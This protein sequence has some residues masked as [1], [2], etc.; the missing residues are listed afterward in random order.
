MSCNN[1]EKI[2]SKNYNFNDKFEKLSKKKKNILDSIYYE[3]NNL[4]NDSIKINHLFE[5]SNQY[6]YI[7][8]K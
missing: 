4:K 3:N 5:L 6:Y 1:K 2:S 7:K 8:R